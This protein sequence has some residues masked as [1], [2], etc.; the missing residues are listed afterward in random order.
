MTNS[1]DKYIP[2]ALTGFVAGIIGAALV[3]SSAAPAGWSL[4]SL[5]GRNQN[6]TSAPF[7]VSNNEMPPANVQEATVISAVDKASPAVVSIVITKDVPVIERYYSSPFDLF[8]NDAFNPFNFRIPQYR[9]RGTEQQEVGGGSGFLVSSDGM[10]VTNKHVV[11]QEEAEYTVFTSKGDKYPAKVVARDP[12][13]DIAIIKIEGNNLPY[14]TFANSDQLRVGQTAIAIGNTLGEF[15]NTVSVGIVSGL[16]RSI[17]AGDRM[18][19]TE[20][21]DQVIQTDAAINPGNSGGPLLNSSGDVIGVNVAMALRGQNI[22]FALPS[23][24]VSSAAE[25]A[26]KTGKIVRPFLGVRYTQITPTMKEANKLAV[27]YG[28]IVTRGQTTE[29]LAVVPGSPADKAGIV[30]GD[31]VLEVEGKKLDDETSLAS[32]IRTKKV[33][34]TVT[35]KIVHKGEEKAVNVRLEEMPQ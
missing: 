29:E 12:S 6:N 19:Q 35:L 22:G 7:T 5:T 13:N 8:G 4:Q 11:N 26:Q 15:R 21:L 27:D 28:V 16:S 3:I 1:Y 25:T 30:E 9:Q 23:N 34:D 17:V 31:I 20:Q 18:G 32:I 2:T 14:L 10:I 33:G 24:V